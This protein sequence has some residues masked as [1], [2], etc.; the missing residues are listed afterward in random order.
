M[1]VYMNQHLSAFN[2]LDALKNCINYWE[3]KEEKH[4]L[5]KLLLLDHRLVYSSVLYV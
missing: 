1:L 3:A 2:V 5:L 4:S